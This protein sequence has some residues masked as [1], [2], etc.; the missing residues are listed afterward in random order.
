MHEKRVAVAVEPTRHWENQTSRP[1]P[2]IDAQL[3]SR[4]AREAQR[5][6]SRQLMNDKQSA[7][8]T[9]KRYY[10]TLP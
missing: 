4:F 1:S 9:P 10:K 3:I 6:V 2:F 7:V 8:K 5:E